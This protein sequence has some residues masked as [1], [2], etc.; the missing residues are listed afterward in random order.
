[1]LSLSVRR[2]CPPLGLPP[3]RSDSKWRVIS[4]EELLSLSV[5]MS[6]LSVLFP[7]GFA[8]VVL[9]LLLLLLSLMLLLLLLVLFVFSALRRGFE[10]LPPAS[11]L[12]LAV[13]AMTLVRQVGQ[14]ALTR[15]HSSTHC[16]WNICLHCKILA[17]SPTTNSFKHIGQEL[18]SFWRCSLVITTNGRVEIISSVAPYWV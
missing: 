3:S 5:R 10:V 2:I 13:S 6:V 17:S 1:M 9:L 7:L 18:S 11:G 8:L 16:L 12:G 14:V 4:L 15:N